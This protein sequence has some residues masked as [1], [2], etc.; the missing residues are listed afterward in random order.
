[1]ECN[2]LTDT[3]CLDF[4]PPRTT[5]QPNPQL[6]WEANILSFTYG[7]AD[8]WKNRF[9]SSNYLN[10]SGPFSQGF[11]A[12]WARLT[13]HPETERPLVGTNGALL[14]QNS[15]EFPGVLQVPTPSFTGLPAIGFSV[16]T[17]NA[18]STNSQYAGVFQHRFDPGVPVT[19]GVV[20]QP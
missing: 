7:A 11:P 18:L 1:V 5:T 4:S 8:T 13:F 19:D 6:C 9:G 20:Q 12:G 14:V 10:F 17:M 2:P 15:T 3:Q 16:M